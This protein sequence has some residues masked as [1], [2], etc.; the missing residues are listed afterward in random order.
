MAE[1]KD[2]E[3]MSRLKEILQEVLR[4][5]ADEI[6][7]ES[8]YEELGADS[9]ELMTLIMVLEDDFQCQISEEAVKEL[10]T[11]GATI[12]YIRHNMAI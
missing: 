6:T 10:T 4:V 5:R 12:A 11:V 8:T 7:P 9:L 2:D 3:I 1:L